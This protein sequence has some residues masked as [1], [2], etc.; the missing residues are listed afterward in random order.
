MKT[1]FNSTHTRITRMI[2]KMSFYLMHVTILAVYVETFSCFLS[3]VCK[4]W[5]AFK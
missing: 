3:I 2:S 1:A 4:V 5:I